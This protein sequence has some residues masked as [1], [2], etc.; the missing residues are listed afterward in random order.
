[1][2]LIVPGSTA[3]Y[4][5]VEPSLVDDVQSVTFENIDVLCFRDFAFWCNNKV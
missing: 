4:Q 3:C 1:M 5:D 2:V